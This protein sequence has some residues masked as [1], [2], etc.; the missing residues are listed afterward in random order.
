MAIEPQVV[1]RDARKHPTIYVL[2]L[3]FADVNIIYADD[4]NIPKWILYA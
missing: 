2:W 3:S 4:D 1:D